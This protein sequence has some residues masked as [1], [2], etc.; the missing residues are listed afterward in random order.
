MYR[1]RHFICVNLIR[2]AI[3]DYK[4][5]REREGERERGIY[6]YIESEIER[7]RDI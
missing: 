5:E 2:I 1:P 6:I 7:V 4:R 3:V